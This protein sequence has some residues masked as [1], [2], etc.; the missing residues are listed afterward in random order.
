MYVYIYIYVTKITNEQA[1]HISAD[2]ES[3][4]RAFS[5]KQESLKKKGRR[6]SS[7]VF[8]AQNFIYN[9]FVKNDQNLKKK[10]L[11]FE[12]STFEWL[13]Y[14]LWYFLNLYV[15]VIFTYRKLRWKKWKIFFALCK[16]VA[17]PKK[18]WVNFQLFTVKA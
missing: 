4:R 8:L 3:Q 14:I 10:V 1:V 15:F 12:I 17:C 18:I 13:L 16:S 11:K 9:I 2:K 6:K 5:R 7:A